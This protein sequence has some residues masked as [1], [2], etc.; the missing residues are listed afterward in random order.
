MSL[1]PRR[2]GDRRRRTEFLPAAIQALEGRA[3]LDN[4]IVATAAPPIHA[5]VGVPLNN[6]VFAT[7]TVSDPTGE[8]GTQWRALINFGDGQKD[9]PIIP[10]EKGSEFEFVD[11]HTYRNPGVYTLTVM[12]AVPGTL[13]PNDNTVMTTVTVATSG[14]DPNQP[15]PTT[16]LPPPPPPH[17]S[18]SGTRLK[19]RIDKLVHGPVAAFGE[20]GT[21]AGEFEAVIGWGDDS[22]PT[23]GTIRARG[24][25]RFLVIGSHQYAERGRFHITVGI[26]ESDG[27]TVETKSI[28]RVI[29]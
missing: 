21:K 15:P 4:G 12:I 17:L 2:H 22:P 9:G 27:Q 13:M 6:A 1:V 10:V 14:T 24:G 28:A 16:P 26:A 5:V 23:T 3:L 19:A 7:Y 25:G 29:R 11:S 18:A 20:R 8:P